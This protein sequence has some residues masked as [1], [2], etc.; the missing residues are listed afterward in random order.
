MGFS[1]A[2]QEGLKVWHFW[3]FSLTGAAREAVPKS[4]CL[5][6][7]LLEYLGRPVVPFYPFVLLGEGS[8]T[9]IDYSKKGYPYSNLSTGGPS[10]FA[11]H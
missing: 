5:R 9:K 4:G 3:G 1:G 8:P 10:Y 7:Y 2:D 6:S 11:W